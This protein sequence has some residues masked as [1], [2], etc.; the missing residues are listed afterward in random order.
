VERLAAQLERLN[1]TPKPL[2]SPLLNGRWELLYTTS[3]SILG[4]KRPALLRPSGPIY[5]LLNGPALR[6]ANRESAPLF[7]SVTAELSPLS[8]NKVAVQFKQFKLLGIIPITAPPSARGELA[9]RAAPR[10]RCAC[11]ALRL[12]C[13]APAAPALAPAGRRRPPPAAADR[14]C[15]RARRRAGDVPRRDAPSLARRQGQ[16]VRAADGRPQ[17]P[18]VRGW[19]RQLLGV[20]R[21]SLPGSSCW[22][23]L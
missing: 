8:A 2:A 4:T 21:P 15:L 16:P 9:V 11:A 23:G 14:R 20:Y 7:S 12:R 19:R 17:G 6:A 13:S 22:G 10:L 5:Q 3:D 18:A 1:P